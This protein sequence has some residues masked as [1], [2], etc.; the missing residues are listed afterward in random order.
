[1]DDRSKAKELEENNPKAALKMYKKLIRKNRYFSERVF[2]S[3]IFSVVIGVLGLL[4]VTDVIEINTI[5]STILLGLV[6]FLPPFIFH[7]WEKIRSIEEKW[8]TMS[9]IIFSGLFLFISVLLTPVIVFLLI[10]L[11]VIVLAGPFL[12]ILKLIINQPYETIMRSYGLPFIIM[13][14]ILTIS[15]HI[16]PDRGFSSPFP[17]RRL[18]KDAITAFFLGFRKILG[19]LVGTMFCLSLYS[20]WVNGFDLNV[21]LSF[22]I[23]GF[24]NGILLC[25]IDINMNLGY[26]LDICMARTLMK[27]E[28][29]HQARFWLG[30]AVGILSTDNLSEDIEEEIYKLAQKLNLKTRSLFD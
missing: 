3:G 10:I 23:A 28:R 17:L 6:A 9:T 25:R 22:G 4:K 13:A 26:E 29:K 18:F 12:V 30:E 15:Y 27:L 5:V 14:A 8:Q 19:I 21:L 11:G 2:F 20:F 1:M 7:S 16:S 24:L